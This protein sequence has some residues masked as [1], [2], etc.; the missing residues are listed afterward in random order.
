[1]TDTVRSGFFAVPEKALFASEYLPSA[2]RRN[3]YLPELGLPR[4]FERRA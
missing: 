3:A 2:Q 1:M 4:S